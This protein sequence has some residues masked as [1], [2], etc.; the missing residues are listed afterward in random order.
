MGW[1]S[2]HSRSIQTVL[3]R[4]D[5]VNY[6]TWITKQEKISGTEEWSV[7]P[8]RIGGGLRAAIKRA[9]RPRSQ[10]IRR[11]DGA[12]RSS[13]PDPGRRRGRWRTAGDFPPHPFRSR[14]ARAR[15]G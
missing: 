15:L 4:G 6:N 13:I 8:P 14:A 1:L 5:V 12:P 11:R 7:R 3:W 10:A 2:F 9:R